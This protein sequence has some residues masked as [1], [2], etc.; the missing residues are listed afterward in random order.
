MEGLGRLFTIEN[1]IITYFSI[2]LD[3]VLME[4]SFKITVDLK[5]SPS[6]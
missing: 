3:I 2:V 4:S 1:V 6:G 5:Q